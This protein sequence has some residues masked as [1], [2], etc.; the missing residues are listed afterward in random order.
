MDDQKN[1]ANM[2][3]A[4]ADS[5]AAA[6]CSLSTSHNYD[7]FIECRDKLKLKLEELFSD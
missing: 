6:A 1:I 2:L 3:M 4:I 5:M 7:V